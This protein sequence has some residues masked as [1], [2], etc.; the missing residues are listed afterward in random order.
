M[1][2][3]CNGAAEHSVRRVEG[4][5]ACARARVLVA[6]REAGGTRTAVD[7]MEMG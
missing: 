4:G 5:T 3:G 7:E 1:G 2:T 6:A